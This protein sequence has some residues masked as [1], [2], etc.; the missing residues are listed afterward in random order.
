MFE[1]R[2]DAVTKHDTKNLAKYLLKNGDTLWV[3]TYYG[4]LVRIRGGE[5][6]IFDA[7]NSVLPNDDVAGLVRG[8]DGTLWVHTA[9]GI[10][11]VKHDELS[12]FE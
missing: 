12:R 3:G 6:T 2:G 9:N 4:G 10:A 8:A 5:L 7:K 1:Q 11:T